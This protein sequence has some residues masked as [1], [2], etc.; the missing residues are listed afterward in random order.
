M[1]ET[2]PIYLLPGECVQICARDDTPKPEHPWTDMRAD[3]PINTQPDD[4][5]FV[6]NGLTDWWIRETGQLDAITIH[7]TLSHNPIG[8][9][10]YITRSVHSGGKGRPTTEYTFWVTID[11]EILYCVDIERGC[12]H[13]HT[14]HQNTHIS[15]GMAGRWDYEPP[16][17]AQMQS[18]ADLCKHLMALYPSIASVKGHC[19]YFSTACP[20]WNGA[21]WK[22]QFYNLLSPSSAFA[23]AFSTTFVL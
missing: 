18:T 12:W 16:P 3:F 9:A 13:D 15:V 21:G 14:G 6:R 23:L 10:D 17:L 19:D 5:Y 20:G 4:P 2:Q 8:I 11:G 7:H 1:T 22:A